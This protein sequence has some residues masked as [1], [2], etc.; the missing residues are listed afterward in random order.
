MYDFRYHEG[1]F[2]SISLNMQDVYRTQQFIQIW[3]GIKGQNNGLSMSFT[4]QEAQST[5]FNLF[6]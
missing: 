4:P 5:T 2:S 1:T 3:E 6:L